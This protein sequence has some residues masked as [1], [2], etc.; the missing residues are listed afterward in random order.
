MYLQFEKE[1]VQRYWNIPYGDDEPTRHPVS[2]DYAM[3]VKCR[4]TTCRVNRNG[5]CGMP[6]ACEIN[7][8]GECETGIAFKKVVKEPKSSLRNPRE[9]D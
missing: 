4:M 8:K 7:A 6:S 9:G 3:G 5:Q 2:R 1:R